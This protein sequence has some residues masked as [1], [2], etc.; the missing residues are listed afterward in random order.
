MKS[1]YYF[2]LSVGGGIVEL[3]NMILEKRKY[4]W[5]LFLGPS[6]PIKKL[7]S[8]SWVFS[9]FIRVVGNLSLVCTYQKN[10][11]FLDYMQAQLKAAIQSKGNASSKFYCFVMFCKKP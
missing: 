9:T 4:K 11:F 8:I 10:K 3:H 1:S 2:K 7:P 5:L 6:F